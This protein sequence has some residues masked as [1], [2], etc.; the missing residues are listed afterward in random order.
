MTAAA[1]S[2]SSLRPLR[3]RRR[4]GFLGVVVRL[5]LRLR[6][7]VRVRE[8][9]VDRS[10]VSGTVNVAYACSLEYLNENVVGP[11]FTEAAGSQFSGTGAAS[12][13]LSSVS[14]PA[15]S[16]RRLRAVGGTT[17]PRS[18]PKF[19]NWYVQY[20]GTSIV[21]AYNPKSK[22]A[23][24]FKAI[25]DGSKPLRTCST[26]MQTPGFKLGRTDPAIDPQGRDFIY[27]LELAQ[28]HYGLPRTR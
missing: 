20:A 10:T 22:Y 9:V 18:S 28:K 12:G 23:S 5:R 21:V 13:T 25:A 27:M 19:T 1:C 24:Q 8:P 11:A 17:S 4:H 14:R 7:R 6:L 26:L 2:S 3:P 15:R 16:S